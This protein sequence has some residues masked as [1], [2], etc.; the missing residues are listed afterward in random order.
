MDC[1]AIEWRPELQNSEL[2]QYEE[3]GRMKI[4]GK[5]ARWEKRN[6]KQ[7]PR[8]LKEEKQNRER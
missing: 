5:A 2:K 7:E 8:E 1:K 6:W 3:E 4:K